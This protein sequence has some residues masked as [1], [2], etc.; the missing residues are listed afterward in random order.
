MLPEPALIAAQRPEPAAFGVPYR[1][2][3]A[4]NVELIGEL[5]DSGFEDRQWLIRRDGRFIQ[6]T[7]PLYRVA[8]HADRTHTLDDIRGRATAA[9]PWVLSTYR[10]RRP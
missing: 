8:E 10:V 3:L 1:P 5:R 7:E 6:V 9:A 4:A 2:A